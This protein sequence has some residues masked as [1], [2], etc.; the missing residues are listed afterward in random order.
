MGDQWRIGGFREGGGGLIEHIFKNNPPK[1]LKN[2]RNQKERKK[3][4]NFFSDLFLLE[5]VYLALEPPLEWDL[6]R[7]MDCEKNH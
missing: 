7:L 4:R 6:F 5:I 1:N 3:N 2:R